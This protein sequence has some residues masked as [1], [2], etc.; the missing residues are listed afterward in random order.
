[1]EFGVVFLEGLEF[2]LQA[3]WDDPQSGPRK[4]GTPSFGVGI[5]SEF[6]ISIEPLV[7][8]QP[9]WFFLWLNARDARRSNLSRVIGRWF[10]KIDPP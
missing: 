7:A 8:A 2:R 3:D 5:R 9:R 6:R 4:R 1:V 10:R